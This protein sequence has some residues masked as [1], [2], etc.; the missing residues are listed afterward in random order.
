[1][2]NDNEVKS[3]MARGGG[4]IIGALL[5]TVAVK[6]AEATFDHFFYK[7]ERAEMARRAG[8]RLES[9]KLHMAMVLLRIH[10]FALLYDCDN[11]PEDSTARVHVDMLRR[12]AVSIRAEL[13]EKQGL[14]EAEETYFKEKASEI[15]RLSDDLGETL[16]SMR[17]VKPTPTSETVV[18]G[19]II[20]TEIKEEIHVERTTEEPTARSE[21]ELA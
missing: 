17:G 19:E 1:M 5:G 10:S 21:E 12:A 18:E 11:E 2:A 8:E 14:T 20:T 13:N 9:I 16:Q 15:K 4:V 3:N 6:V 7:K